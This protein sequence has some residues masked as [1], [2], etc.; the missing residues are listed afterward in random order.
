MREYRPD[1][2][3]VSHSG[4]NFQAHFGPFTLAEARAFVR[5]NGFG[6]AIIPIFKDVDWNRDADLMR[7]RALIDDGG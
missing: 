4:M 2:Y 5:D 6:G 1:A 3:V 7:G